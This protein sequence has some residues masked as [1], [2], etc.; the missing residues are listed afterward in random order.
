M[1]QLPWRPAPADPGGLADSPELPPDVSRIQGTASPC[2]EDKILIAP[3]RTP[4]KVLWFACLVLGA[5]LTAVACRQ[6]MASGFTGIPV[7]PRMRG[8]ATARRKL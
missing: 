2:A 6:K 1:T 5:P 4:E 3:L 8:G 7:M